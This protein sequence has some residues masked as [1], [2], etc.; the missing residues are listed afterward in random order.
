M[1][2]DPLQPETVHV[3][4][5]RN[6]FPAATL[7]VH[8]V[9]SNGGATWSPEQPMSVGPTPLAYDFVEQLVALGASACCRYRRRSTRPAWPCCSRT[10]WAS[11]T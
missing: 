11:V 10:S 2:V 6:H 5:V 8:R 7:A 1:A 9:S 4:Y 3:A